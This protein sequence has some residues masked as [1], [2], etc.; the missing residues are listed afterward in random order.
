M[1]TASSEQAQKQ[2][3]KQ[4][5]ATKISNTKHKCERRKRQRQWQQQRQQQRRR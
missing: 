3:N 2:I 5:S 4:E 1:A